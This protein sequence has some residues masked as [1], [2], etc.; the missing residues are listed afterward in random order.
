MTTAQVRA[1][2][3][4]GVGEVGRNM[5]ALECGDEIVILDCGIMFPE[6]EMLGIDLVLPDITYL[7]DKT[8]RIKGILLSHGHEDHIGAVPY[9]LA[10]LGFPPIYG[11]RLTMGLLQ[12]KLK[13]HRLLDRA[14]LATFQLVSPLRSDPGRSS[15][16]QSPTPSPTPPASASPHRQVWSSTSPTGSSTIPPRLA[17]RPILPP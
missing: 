4:G 13:E 2:P 17:S 8:E 15:P 3:L 12:G 5:W 10:D 11:S 7:R 14:K 16:S 9:L 1:I 6:E